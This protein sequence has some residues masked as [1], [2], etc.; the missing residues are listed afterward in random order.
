MPLF[1]T[2]PILTGANG[3]LLQDI[4][5]CPVLHPSPEGKCGGP[6]PSVWFVLLVLLSPKLRH[7]ESRDWFSHPLFFFLFVSVRFFGSWECNL[8]VS[9]FLCP[10]ID[11]KKW[12]LWWVQLYM[13]IPFSFLFFFFCKSPKAYWRDWL[14][15]LMDRPRGQ[16][17]SWWLIVLVLSFKVRNLWNLM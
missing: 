3:S 12:V 15:T 4:N 13:S 7:A 17:L 16:K 11:V 10:S 9:E 6:H 8:T 5:I 1:P 2:P 14:I